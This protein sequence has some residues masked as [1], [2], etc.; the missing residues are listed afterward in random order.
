[1]ILKSQLL[2]ATHKTELTKFDAVA[3]IVR[4]STLSFEENKQERT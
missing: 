2:I 1:M 4:V 3:A